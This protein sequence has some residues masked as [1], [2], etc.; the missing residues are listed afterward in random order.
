MLKLAAV[1]CALASLLMMACSSGSKAVPTATRA[2]L[3]SFE[4][5]AGRGAYGVGVTTLTMDDTSRATAPN[6]DAPGT[7]DRKMMVEVWY[8]IAAGAS[9]AEVR[10]APLL[11]SDARYPLIIFA[12]GLSSFARQ[13]ASYTQHLASHGYIVAAPG[14]PQSRIDTPGGPRISVV[15]DQPADASF[16]IDEM[17]RM[18]AATE[19]TFAAAIDADRI[20]MTGHSLGG[21][22]TMLSIYG[23]L[24][25]ARI[26]AA[27]AFAPFACVLPPDIAGGA[28]VP[29][30]VV[31]GT[32]D[33][34]VGIASIRVAY[35]VARAPKYYAEITGAD[36]IQFGDFNLTDDKL[37]GDVISTVTRGGVFEEVAGVAKGLHSDIGQCATREPLTGDPITHERQLELMRALSTPFFDAKLRGDAAGQRFLDETLPSIAGVRVEMDVGR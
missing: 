35:E 3:P 8:P 7:P 12:H 22:T 29:V 25:D 24:R 17:L 14:F 36:H 23:P 31:G 6:R 18:S 37:G 1:F 34:I 20:G 5:E 28:S 9:E 4:E 10:D 15:L 19:G 11:R 21:L 26:K 16:V 13:S 30:M 2:A 33:R 32:R 27:I